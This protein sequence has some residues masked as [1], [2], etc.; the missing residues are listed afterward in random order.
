MVHL[1]RLRAEGMLGN[2]LLRPL[3]RPLLE[4]LDDFIAK[5][6]TGHRYRQLPKQ[7]YSVA[8]VLTRL[9]GFH[10]AQPLR[11][12]WIVKSAAL[13]VHLLLPAGWRPDEGMP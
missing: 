5:P 10:A 6:E 3:H 1:L 4:A 13:D 7:A 9:G 2:Q 11:R 8:K 12:P